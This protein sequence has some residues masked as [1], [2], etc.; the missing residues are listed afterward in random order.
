MLTSVPTHLNDNELREWLIQEIAN[1]DDERRT[2]KA[3]IANLSRTKLRTKSRDNADRD[4]QLKH[5]G[6]LLLARFQDREDLRILL[7]D[8]NAR[9]RA[10][11]RRLNSAKKRDLNLAAAFMNVAEEM[12]D[13]DLF[14]TIELEALKI[15]R[16]NEDATHY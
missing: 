9:I 16:T 5:L 14:A 4:A 12:L 2:I 7:G 1:V 8:V 10:T 13:P 15:L 6:E 3:D 11:N